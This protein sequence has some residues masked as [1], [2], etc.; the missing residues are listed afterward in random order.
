M[1]VLEC[2]G[3]DGEWTGDAPTCPHEY[4]NMNGFSLL[5]KHAYTAV[6]C[7]ALAVPMNGMVDTSSG[8][9]FMNTATYTCNDGYGLMGDMTRTCQSD[10]TWS[11]AALTCRSES[12]GFFI[13]LQ[14]SVL[15]VIYPDI[16]YPNGMIVYIPPTTLPIEAV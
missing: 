14:Y 16:N 5:S 15:T 6:D 7:G 13:V 12:V 4:N 8:T 1:V 11:P 2:V 3:A 9:T 10:G